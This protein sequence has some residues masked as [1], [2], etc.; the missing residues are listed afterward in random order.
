[1]RIL[2]LAAVLA[3]SML[4]PSTAAAAAPAPKD[5][6][7]AACT[8][9][10]TVEDAPSGPSTR[11]AR[12]LV[13]VDGLP[14][15]RVGV[16]RLD[17]TGVTCEVLY[18]RGAL[19]RG[20]SVKVVRNSSCRGFDYALDG[21]PQEEGRSCSSTAGPL[22][23]YSGGWYDVPNNVEVLGVEAF[24][25]HETEVIGAE[26]GLPPE[27]VGATVSTVH[28]GSWWSVT[29]SGTSLARREFVR[30]RATDRAARAAY[31]R[32][33]AR[34]ARVY[35]QRVAEIEE[36]GRSQAWKEWQTDRAAT[37]RNESVALARKK[38]RLALEGV[39]LVTREL[40]GTYS[41]T[42]PPVA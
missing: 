28:T 26:P 1:M 22:R 40:E 32:Q 6:R 5:W 20:A 18:V 24:R 12:S 4:V 11:V 14:G 39:R 23:L 9:G 30:S 3:A 8:D 25:G 7:A 31:T 2:T 13:P 29:L 34:A 42:L 15:V 41:G 38:R 17:F 37:V 19:P 27:L 36:S 10:G 35:E 33:V 21:V 16:D